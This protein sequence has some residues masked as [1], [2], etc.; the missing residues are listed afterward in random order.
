ME[1]SELKGL[2]D[3][4]VDADAD[5]EKAENLLKASK[6]KARL[7]REET[8]PGVMMEMELDE[9]KLDTGEK[10]SIKQDVYASIPK[11]STGAAYEWLDKNG[12]GG[13]I[14]TDVSV[15]YGRGDLEAAVDL[16]ND[17]ADKGLEVDMS[18]SVNAQTLKAFLRE[19]IA[20]GCEIP[21]DLFGARPIW[22]TK[23]TKSKK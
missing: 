7:L 23:I 1:L 22:T 4:L 19:Q 5:V 12:F 8:I 14:K 3:A 15:S 2:I 20:K 13:M 21:L 9:V 10:V 6:E 17:L 18:Q 11:A 16:R